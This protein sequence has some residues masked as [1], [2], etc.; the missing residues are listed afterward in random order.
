MIA[1]AMA[2][3][4]PSQETDEEAAASGEPDEPEEAEKKP[5]PLQRVASLVLGTLL[6]LLVGEV[7]VRI[8]V[9]QTLI[10]NIEMVRYAKEL[11][12]PDPRGEV[13]HV[14]RPNASA[15]LMGVDI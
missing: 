6:A 14:H 2:S 9:T 15:H 4:E 8:V 3:A 13:S 5:H 11:K 1:R 10:Y 7:V 12:T